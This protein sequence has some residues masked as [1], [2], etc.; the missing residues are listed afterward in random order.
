MLLLTIFIHSFLFPPTDCKNID[1]HYCHDG[2][3]VSPPYIPAFLLMSS[4]I[5]HTHTN[6]KSHCNKSN[7]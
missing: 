4:G 5:I 3:D 6:Q 2:S 1:G 7:P